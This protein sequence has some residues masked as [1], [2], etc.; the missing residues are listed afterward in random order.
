MS[1]QHAPLDILQ[2]YWG[3]DQFRPLQESIIQSVLEGRDSLALMPTGGGKSVCYQ[4]PALCRD[5][6]CLV[7]SPLIALMKDQVFQLQQRNIRAEAIYSGMHRQDIDRILDNCVYGDV[8]LLY[9]SP[10]RLQTELARE[11]IRRMPVNLIAVDEAHCVSQ[12]GYDFRPSYLQIPEIRELHPDVP[13]LAL[14]ATATEEVV[15]D[16]QE[17]LEFRAENVFRMSFERQNLAY[18]VL[19]EEDKLG[20]MLEIFRN[21]KGSGIAYART[22]RKTKEVAG[23]L[24]KK[25]ISADYY[26]A[27]LSNDFRSARQEAWINGKI[28]IMVATNAFGMG[29]DK[30]DVRT[31]VHLDVPD[32]LEAY[33]QEAGRAGRDG[34]KSYA[35]LLYQPKDRLELEKRFVQSFPEMEEIRKTYLS[36]G[37]YFQLAVGGGSGKSYDIDLQNFTE[38]YGLDMIRTYNC[39]KIL[40]QSAW[41]TLSEAIYV[42][43]SLRVIVSKDTLYDYQLRNRKLDS[44][45]KTILRTYQGAFS[46]RVHL[47]EKQLAGFLKISLVELQQGLEKL[48][49]DGIIEYLPQKEKPQITFV[50]ERVGTQNLTIDRVLYDFR[51]KRFRERIRHM[52][53]YGEQLAC[54]SQQL[55]RYFG[56]SN[57][58][59][60]GIC[61]VCLGRNKV[62]LSQESFERYKH[63]IRQLLKRNQMK[64]TEVVDSFAPRRREEVL[65][66]LEYLI[67]EGLLVEENEAVR[68]AD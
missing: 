10:E 50:E 55:L 28:R 32:S 58:P 67:D 12:W 54:R 48:R 33:Y 36:L 30:P 35:V 26:H 5:G 34:Q 27:G 62:T 40:E 14:T 38:T 11:R 43:S 42:P 29:I 63:K 6:I 21:V 31:V 19:Q 52:M 23:F 22:R 56:Q 53:A 2:R 49:K 1:Q 57:P 4:V 46:H 15:N 39:L 17:K 61:D 13:V 3:Y 60:C 65:K 20:K 9:L 66:T 37:S 7:V 45:L 44:L 25:G 18:V 8:K 47:R 24:R 68:W 41:L 59:A 64:V 51:K 16:I